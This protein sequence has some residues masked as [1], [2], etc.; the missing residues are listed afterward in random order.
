[1]DLKNKLII[2]TNDAPPL[3]DRNSSELVLPMIP[4]VVAEDITETDEQRFS[5]VIST[6][7]TDAQK[8]QVVAPAQVFQRQK[9]VLALHW[10]PEFVPMSLIRERI[11]STFPSKEDELIIPTQHNELL[12]Y[13]GIYSGVEIDCF[14]KGFNQKVQLLLHLTKDRAEKASVLKSMASY[15]YKYRSSQL[16]DFINSIIGE[17][18]TRLEI[19]AK[20]VGA[21]RQL[22]GF[23]VGT[24]SKIHKLM[25]THHD[26]IPQ[27]M[28]K[29]KILRNYFDAMRGD[30]ADI[31]IERT[32]ALLRA[33]KKLVKA[34]FPLTFFYRAEEVIE[35]AR[36][37]GAGIVI[38]HPEQFWPILLA[39][40]DVDGIEIWNP[41]SRKYTEFLISVINTKNSNLKLGENR[42]LVFMGDD[43]HMGEKVKD[44]A[45]WNAEKAAREIGV[46]PGW[47]DLFIRKKL[48]KAGME[49]TDVIREYRQRLS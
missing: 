32:Q 11:D 26:H 1:M 44:P 21:N 25:D 35:E 15:T 16:Y 39:D 49:I 29:N 48:I 27:I 31:I 20:E 33:V 9:Q 46:Q 37:Q 5:Q 17:D 18:K 24:V 14:S 47:S 10:H 2:S 8:A 45:S 6:D 30:V 3:T 43:T 41:Q 19:A 13:D 42:L 12:S 38:P 40:Y 36:S 22:V 4:E 28:I 34:D 7:L 23:V